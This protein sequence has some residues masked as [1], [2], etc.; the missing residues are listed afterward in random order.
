MIAEATSA[1]F[2]TAI[3]LPSSRVGYAWVRLNGDD[4]GLYTTVENVD[5]T[6]AKRWFWLTA[7]VFCTKAVWRRC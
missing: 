6:F 3:G 4:Y 2:L 1:A 5:K 7:L